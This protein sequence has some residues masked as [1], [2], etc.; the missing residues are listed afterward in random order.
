MNLRSI[1]VRLGLALLLLAG[2][3]LAFYHRQNSGLGLGGPISLPKMFWLGYALAAWFVVPFFLWHDSRLDASV[4]R[5]FSVF[6]L[7]MAARGI[8]EM[9]LLHV[10]HHWTPVYG[11]SHDLLCMAALVVLRN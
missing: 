8:A 4:R 9:V 6:W 3:C 5:V 11:I 7:L 10:F 2:L 1:R